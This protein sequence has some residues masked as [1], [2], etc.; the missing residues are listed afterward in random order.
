MIGL[1]RV[2]RRVPVRRAVAAAD[3]AAL[4]RWLNG[5]SRKTLGSLIELFKERG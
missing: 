1:T 4:E 5:D 2:P 3:L